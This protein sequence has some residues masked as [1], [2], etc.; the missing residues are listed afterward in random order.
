MN[1]LGV[2]RPEPEVDHSPPS[3]AKFKK[4]VELHSHFPIGFQGVVF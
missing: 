3:K 2:K 1:F 4:G